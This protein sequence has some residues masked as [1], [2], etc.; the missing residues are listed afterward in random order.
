MLTGSFASVYYG[1]PRSTQDVDLVIDPTREQLSAL[2]ADLPT[3]EY[4]ADMDAAL[5]ARERRS[6][7][8][9][10]DMKTGWKIDM[11]IRKD[12]PFSREEFS[13][14]QQ[15]IVQGTSLFVAS[16][17]DIILAKLEWA[18]LA[19][20]SRQIEDAA[21][22]MRIRWD[23]LDQPYLQ[24]WIPQLALEKEWKDALRLADIS[25]RF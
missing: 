17:E 8:N 9:I 7:F 24:R 23:S 11:I 1:S 25:R 4:Y 19:Q 5:E 13:R 6:L 12:R 3:N 18:R 2:I 16:V 15:I 21:G 20:S 14:R 10:I 22:V